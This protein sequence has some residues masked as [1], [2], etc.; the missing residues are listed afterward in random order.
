MKGTPLT[1]EIY[2]YVV[3]NFARDERALLERM[4]ARAEVAGV[5]M[6]MVSED[7]AKFIE[8]FLRAI[9]ARNVLDVGTLFGYSAAIMSRAVGADGTVTSLEY[10]QM[11]GEVARENL[12]AERISNVNVVI[13]PALDY[14]KGMPSD[15]IDFVLIDA[16]KVNYVNY[17]RESLRLVKRG[18]VIAGD[19]AMAFGLLMADLPES[20]PEFQ[21]VNAIRQFNKTFAAERSLFSIIVPTGDGMAMGVVEK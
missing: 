18:G 5:P 1:E 7:Q 2:Q 20:D 3:D 19:N 4:Q 9:K 15:S 10:N 16:D 8:F 14:M 11:H 12:K 13:G 21:S 6:I 17:M